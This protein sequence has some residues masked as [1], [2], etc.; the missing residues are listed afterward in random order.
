MAEEEEATWEVVLWF[1]ETNLWVWIMFF[2]LPTAAELEDEQGRLARLLFG[3][4]LS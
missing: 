1:Q 2:P 4:F 3:V